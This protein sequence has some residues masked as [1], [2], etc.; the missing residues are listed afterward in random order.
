VPPAPPPPK[1]PNPHQT[2]P[3]AILYRHDDAH[4]EADHVIGSGLHYDRIAQRAG[5]REW[6]TVADNRKAPHLMLRLGREAATLTLAFDPGTSEVGATRTA[7][8]VASAFGWPVAEVHT[9]R[10]PEALY[11]ALE[12]PDAVRPLLPGQSRV[13]VEL[14]GLREAL[15]KEAKG[16]PP[17]VVR[18]PNA[19]WV[20][21]AP[22]A[23]ARDGLS[24][25][26]FFRADDE[27]ST[28]QVDYGISPAMFWGLAASLAAWVTVPFVAVSLAAALLRRKALLNSQRL[29]RLGWAL[30]A[31]ASSAVLLGT[32]PSAAATVQT[33]APPDLA[34]PMWGFAAVPFFLTA[35]LTALAVQITRFRACPPPNEARSRPEAL[36][37]PL[38]L[39]GLALSAA[40]GLPA[41]ALFG[42]THPVLAGLL[43]AVPIAAAGLNGLVWQARRLTSKRAPT[44]K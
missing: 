43:I 4:H 39:A 34:L 3:P 12:P 1:A 11:V 22:A 37:L 42:D 35:Y 36:R 27:A 6:G 7:A 17:L 30:S 23:A 9:A 18:C 15:G 14:S 32:F 25:S 41:Q 33:M 21:S 29:G 31:P 24:H 16:A 10:H 40:I 44:S 26:S 20:E 38:L 13:R 8:R 2:R 5:F 19:F 28:L